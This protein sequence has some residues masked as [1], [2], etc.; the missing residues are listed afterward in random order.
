MHKVASNNRT[1]ILLPRVFLAHRGLT[2]V[3]S[4]APGSLASLPSLPLHQTERCLPQPQ[5]FTIARTRIP[6]ITLQA[7]AVPPR[8]RSTS[9]IVRR[10][11]H[12]STNLDSIL[13]TCYLQG[14]PWGIQH[15]PPVHFYRAGPV[16][17]YKYRTWTA[18]YLH[19]TIDWNSRMQSSPT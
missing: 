9:A 2:E 14:R 12:Q 8:S 1:T 4:I 7:N 11:L 3:A 19:N 5:Q 6:R 10:Y 17:V 13:P 18:L 16:R 15:K